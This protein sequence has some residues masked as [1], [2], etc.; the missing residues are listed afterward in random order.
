[1]IDIVVEPLLYA[2]SFAMFAFTNFGNDTPR[3][4]FHH[5][6]Q[7]AVLDAKRAFILEEDDPIASSEMADTIFGF[8]GMTVIDKAALDPSVKAV[9]MVR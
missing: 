9:L 3:G 6:G 8:E 4:G 1:M 7:H 2:D 5:L